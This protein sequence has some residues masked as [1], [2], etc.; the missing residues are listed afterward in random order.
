[1]PATALIVILATA[2]PGQPPPAVT[3]TVDTGTHAHAADPV[4]ACVARRLRSFVGPYGV[5]QAWPVMAS[6]P[7]GLHHTLGTPL[8]DTGMVADG[9]QQFLHVDTDARA[10]YVIEQGGFA[11]T[12]KVYGPLP[13]SQC[14]PSDDAT[15]SP[16]SPR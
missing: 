9:Y 8:S 11:G 1:M 5:Q 14:A 12:F 10:V 15:E 4:T 13:L 7:A 6:P 2:T 3:L 16:A